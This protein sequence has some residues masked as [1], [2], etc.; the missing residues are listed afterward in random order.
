MT[1]V[2]ITSNFK[3]IGIGATFSVEAKTVSRGKVF[4][5]LFIYF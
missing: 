3:E 2:N 4:I 5:Y 1:V